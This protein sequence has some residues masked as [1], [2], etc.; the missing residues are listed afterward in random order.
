MDGERYLHQDVTKE[1]AGFYV[2]VVP[3]LLVVALALGW[4]ARHY[5]L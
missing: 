2:L 5:W 3:T 1:L 4:I